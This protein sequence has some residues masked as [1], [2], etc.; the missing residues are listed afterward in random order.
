M[1]KFISSSE[2]LGL[3]D[4]GLILLLIVI[5]SIKILRFV[6]SFVIS[7]SISIGSSGAILYKNKQKIYINSFFFILFPFLFAV[8]SITFFLTYIIYISSYWS[9][10]GLALGKRHS[11][12]PITKGIN[13]SRYLIISNDKI[14][15]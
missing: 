13:D 7:S 4:A 3:S 14:G 2:I 6:K 10:N 9:K 8:R 1:Q 12:I 5:L 15:I 11:C